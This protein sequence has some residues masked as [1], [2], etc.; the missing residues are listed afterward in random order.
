MSNYCYDY[1]EEVKA[2]PFYDT[3]ISCDDMKNCINELRFLENQENNELAVIEKIEYYEKMLLDEFLSADYKKKTRYFFNLFRRN[4]YPALIKTLLREYNDN[5]NNNLILLY[6]KNLIKCLL[7]L[8]NYSLLHSSEN[9]L[10]N[11]LDSKSTLYINK[12]LD[13]FFQLFQRDFQKCVIFIEFVRKSFKETNLIYINYYNL[14]YI[15]KKLNKSK[16]LKNDQKW[17]LINDYLNVFQEIG[18]KILEIGP[19]E[20]N[21]EEEK[22][23][24]DFILFQLICSH[25]I[26]NESLLI[27][28]ITMI[29]ARNKHLNLLFNVVNSKENMIEMNI[30]FGE[31]EKL[32]DINLLKKL[33]D[34]CLDNK[35]KYQ[36]RRN[37][38]IS[39]FTFISKL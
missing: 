5:N 1:N 39:L 19:L 20:I 13:L 27:V 26:K 15:I 35:T 9:N 4:S 2:L 12:G 21:K 7:F 33:N 18:V 38:L 23:E 28:K 17:S 25:L 11:I 8:E 14:A 31:E 16:Y 30:D 36:R 3:F 24:Y 10:S 32:I 22:E 34:K 29:H 6:L 37:N